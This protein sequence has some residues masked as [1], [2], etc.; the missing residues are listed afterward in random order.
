MPR[1]PPKPINHLH[2]RKVRVRQYAY[3]N[4]PSGPSTECPGT[5]SVLQAFLLLYNTY[6]IKAIVD[7][8]IRY[9]H[10]HQDNT[11]TFTQEDFIAY[12]AILLAMC[13]RPAPRL[14]DYWSEDPLLNHPFIYGLMGRKRFETIHKWLHFNILFVETEVCI[15]NSIINLYFKTLPNRY[16]KLFVV[17]GC[18]HATFVLTKEWV[19]GKDEAKYVFISVTNHIQMV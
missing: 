14:R 13:M 15:S 7:D 11:F 9:A 3:S 1:R 19:L 10:Q 2:R 5:A 18:R 6:I 12:I 4:N 17:I 8:T 16:G